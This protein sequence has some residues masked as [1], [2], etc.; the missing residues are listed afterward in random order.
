MKHLSMRWGFVAAGALISLA[1]ARAEDKVSSLAVYPPDVNLSTKAD[2]QRFIVVATR[3]DGVTL[4]VTGQAVVKLTDSKLCRVDKGAL[5]PAADGE[6]KLEVEYQ[7]L[8]SSATVKVQD[9]AAERPISFQ[10]DVMPVF[11]RGGCN[12]GSCHGAAR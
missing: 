12:T 11:M 8:K 4:D 10:L 2:S 3:E 6:T 5:Y 1:A 9:A 7:G